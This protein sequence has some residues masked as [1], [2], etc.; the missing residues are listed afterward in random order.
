MKDS[1]QPLGISYPIDFTHFADDIL[2]RRKGKLLSDG[3]LLNYYGPMLGWRRYRM[4]QAIFI[5]GLLQTWERNRNDAAKNMALLAA[6]NLVAGGVHFDKETIGFPTAF[7]VLGYKLSPVWYSAL[8]QSF[9]ASAFCR[10]GIVESDDSWI[11]HGTQAMR[12]V[13]KSRELTTRDPSGGFWYQ[14][15][16]TKPP[17]PV[18]NGHMY[19]TIG[20]LDVGLASR[21]EECMKYFE[22]GVSAL[23]AN[24]PSFDADGLAFYDGARRILAK[25]YYQ[26]LHVEQ[27][28][29]LESVTGEPKLAEFAD[30]WQ[31]GFQEKWGIQSWLSYA[32]TTFQSG[33]RLEGAKFPLSYLSYAL[34]DS[35]LSIVPRL[36]SPFGKAPS[37]K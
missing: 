32:E 33:F 26:R 13:M 6:K 3:T 30:R 23:L 19:A 20:F 5:L 10:V 8:A 37:P 22:K 15:Y 18:L 7:T 16:P 27:L 9:C 2:Q 1:V 25:P 29:F 4:S 35:G 14:E 17:T 24:L 31:K 36:L 34:G 21:D 28:R 11:D 12:F